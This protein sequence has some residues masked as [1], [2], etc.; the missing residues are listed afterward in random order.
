MGAEN[1]I[2]RVEFYYPWGVP[3]AFKD[4][5]QAAYFET[6][7]EDDLMCTQ[8]QEGRRNLH[9]RG[10]EEYGPY[11]LPMEEGMKHFHA[12]VREAMK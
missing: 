10:I 7:E 6:A 5:H 8:M 12:W 1:C 2:N 9:K 4:A 3:R 11:Q